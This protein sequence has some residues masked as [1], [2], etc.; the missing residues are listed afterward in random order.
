[1]WQYTDKVM[2][3]FRNPKNM[4]TIPDADGVGEVGSLAC[5]DAMRLMFKLDPTRTRI[6]DAR[7]QT[8]GCTSAIASSEALIEMIRGK[9]LAEA[10]AIT[11]KDIVNYLGG[12]PEQKMHCSVMGEEALQAA[13]ENFRTGR[14]GK[15]IVEGR[16]V[17]KCFGVTEEEIERVVRG[18][19]LQ[20]VEQ[21]T[22]YCKAGGACGNCKPQIA[23][24]IARVRRD[25][26]AA[27]PPPAPKKLTPIRRIHL[28]EETLE[29]EIRPKL[30]AD[31]GDVELVNVDGDRVTISFRGMCA[32]CNVSQ[33]TMK[34]VVEA[35][36]REFVSPELVVEEHR[37]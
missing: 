29:R 28:I 4:G 18:N 2:D 22:N 3:L 6:A 27:T 31:G 30:Q 24:I 25:M 21:V 17:C 8:F 23:A 11:N 34:D 15:K 35:K 1:M 12:L 19:D 16:I 26:A 20:T 5:G 13:M 7:Y 14:P 36:L 37:E 10:A 32:Q 33:F 9:T